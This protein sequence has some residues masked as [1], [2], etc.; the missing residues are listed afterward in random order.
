LSKGAE[1]SYARR[2]SLFFIWDIWWQGVGGRNRCE[3]NPNED[4]RETFCATILFIHDDKLD[5]VQQHLSAARKS[6][7]GSI[8]LRCLFVPIKGGGVC[9]GGGIVVVFP[10]LSRPRGKGFLYA[11]I[12]ELE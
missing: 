4:L 12:L 7:V 8:E 5:S 3:R 11:V 2:P 10:S 9:G 6:S 1:K